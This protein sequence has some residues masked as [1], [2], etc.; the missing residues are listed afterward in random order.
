MITLGT[1]G[2]AVLPLTGKA[3]I[4]GALAADM[5]GTEMSIERL[6]IGEETGAGFPLATM[7]LVGWGRLPC[8]GG[9]GF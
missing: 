2:A 4:A 7:L 3:E 1:S 5:I 8:A 6:G 9:C